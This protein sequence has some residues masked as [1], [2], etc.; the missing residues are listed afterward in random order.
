MKQITTSLP[1]DSA[2][3]APVLWIAVVGFLF[4]GLGWFDLMPNHEARVGWELEFL[5]PLLITLAMLLSVQRWAARI[6]YPA[7]VTAILAMLACAVSTLL[8]AVDKTALETEAGVR[9]GYG[10]YAVA[11]LFGS[12]AALLALRHKERQRDAAARHAAPGCQV[13]CS[14]SACIHASFFALSVGAMGFL[15]WG[16]G[17]VAHT[18][19]PT[20]V[21]FGWCLA[22]VGAVLVTC[23]LA[24]HW[25]HI[26]ARFGRPAALIGIASGAVWAMG[27]VLEAVNPGAGVLS[28]W[29]SDLFACYGVGHVLNAWSLVLVIRRRTPTAR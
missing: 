19:Q 6:G 25:E 11:L 16:L 22:A 3:S 2:V 14:C 24:S 5:G 29:Y 20:G 17:F 13:G 10:A 4:W 9:F 28:S 15:I 21:E 8:F 23:A 26:A 7:A 18:I 12:L 1:S 27:Y